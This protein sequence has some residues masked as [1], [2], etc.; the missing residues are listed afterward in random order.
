MLLMELMKENLW[1]YLAGVKGRLSVAEQ[2]TMCRDIA[3][4]LVYLHQQ[5]PPI[6]YCALSDLNNLTSVNILIS[7]DGQVKLGACGQAQQKPPVGYFDEIQPGSPIYMPSEALRR[8][9][10]YDEKIDVFSLGVV[11][12][13]IATQHPRS[14]VRFEKEIKRRQPDLSKIPEDHPL[15]P[16]ILQCLQDNAVD[17]P[18]STSV[19]KEMMK[20]CPVS[21]RKFVIIQ[22]LILIY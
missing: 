8:G 21:Q 15:K 20:I 16:I 18:N 17:R 2:C 14:S 19:L 10:H 12:T 9:A 6:A 11:M 7:F 3:S 4:A 22:Y 13:E 1:E 5:D